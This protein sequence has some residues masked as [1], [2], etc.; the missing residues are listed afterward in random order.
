MVVAD[1]QILSS[2][3]DGILFV[4]QPGVT[5]GGVAKTIIDDL[6]RIDAHILGVVLNRIPRN[7]DLYYGGYRYYSPYTG[8]NKYTNMGTEITNK[9]AKPEKEIIDEVFIGK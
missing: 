2:K 3:V 7:R 4:I 8:K 6:R 9:N 1:V 5:H